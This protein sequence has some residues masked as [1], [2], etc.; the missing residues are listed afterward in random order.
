[1]SHANWIYYVTSQPPLRDYYP[2][3]DSEGTLLTEVSRNFLKK[4]TPE[5]L[6][7]SVMSVYLQKKAD[8]N[9]YYYITG[10]PSNKRNGILKPHGNI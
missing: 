4:G 10:F 3:E 8:N 1:M 7:S 6:R 9:G 2:R 5:W